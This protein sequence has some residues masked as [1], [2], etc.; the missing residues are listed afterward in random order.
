MK[1]KLLAVLATFGMVA[2][3]SAV[4]INNNLSINGFIDG[5]WV[6]SDSGAANDDVDLDIDEVELNFIFNAGNVSGELHIDDND[7]SADIGN[8]E[9]VHFTYGFSN[10]INLQ[11]GR[12]GSDLGLEREDPAGLYTFSRAYGSQIDV[13]PGTAVGEVDNRDLFNLGNVDSLVGEGVRVS[14]AA[15]K[16]TASFAAYNAQGTAEESSNPASQD[17]LDYEL[18]LTFTGIDNVVIGG[19]AQGQ[20]SAT[21]ND[22]TD[23]VNIYATYTLDKLLL[24][25]EY[26]N[27]DSEQLGDDLTA[28]SLLADYDINDQLGIAVR[29][30]EWETAANEESDQLTI[31]PNYALTS[32]LGAILEYSSTED[33]DGEEVDTLAL[34]LTFT[35]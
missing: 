11:V 1:N 23:T 28:Y 25:A 30:S 33:S 17:D 19:G 14:Y 7:D 3:A 16:F 21:D 26:V 32:S 4:K 34:E 8:I 5:S 20:R 18:A 35:F 15:D 27:A 31:A 24:G 9:Q 6:S 10:G 2:S 13:D 12:F 29:Y 22:D